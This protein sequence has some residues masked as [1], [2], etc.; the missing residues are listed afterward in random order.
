[1]LEVAQTLETGAFHVYFVLRSVGA[2][3]L[4]YTRRVEIGARDGRRQQA[5]ATAEHV[6]DISPKVIVAC[7]KRKH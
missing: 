5:A 7:G 1:M 4:T 2:A 6:D 3:E